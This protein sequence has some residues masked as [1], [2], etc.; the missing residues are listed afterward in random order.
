MTKVKHHFTNKSNIACLPTSKAIIYN[1]AMSDNTLTNGLISRLAELNKKGFSKTE[2]ARVAGVSKQ[3]VSS[4]FKTG[5]IS[6]SSALA[7][8]DAAGVSVPWLLGEDVGEK[9]GLKP[10]EQ[11]LLELY[12]QL[13]EE[14]QQNMLRIVSLRLKEL[15]ELYAKYMGRRIKGDAD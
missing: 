1:E 9:D 4:W 7:I 12:R 15:D 2:M 13:P 5:R 10:D 11:R 3:A 6:K 8:A 14:E